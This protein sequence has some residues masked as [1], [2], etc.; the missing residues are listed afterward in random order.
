MTPTAPLRRD[1][2]EL[3]ALAWPVVLS[4]L[5]IMTMGLVDIIVVGR[6]SATQ[7]GY[8]ALGWAPS[9]VVVTTAVG[10]VM[11]VVSSMVGQGFVPPGSPFA[12]VDRTICLIPEPRGPPRNPARAGMSPEAWTSWA[13]T[14]IS[15]QNPVP[16]S[17]T[18]LRSASE[19]RILDGSSSLMLARLGR[20]RATVSPRR[21]TDP[22]APAT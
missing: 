15:T 2:A 5:G 11:G 13:S 18:R 8:H 1:F 20:R 3:L 22:C 6:Y 17:R 14:R 4:R 16:S 19:I 12:N 7:L 21:R 9:A 10:L